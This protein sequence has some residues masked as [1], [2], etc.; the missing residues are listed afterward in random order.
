MAKRFARSSLKLKMRVRFL[1]CSQRTR[2]AS[3]LSPYIASFEL[4]SYRRKGARLGDEM[5]FQKHKLASR[6]KLWHAIRRVASGG[7]QGG[8]FSFLPPRFISCPPRYFLGWEKLL[9]CLN[10]WFRPGKAFEFRRRPFFYGDHLI[11]TET[12]PQS[13]SGTMKKLCPPNFDFP[14][15]D[16]A[17]LAKPLHVMEWAYCIGAA[18]ALPQLKC[19]Q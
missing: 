12:S 3:V 10:L 17:K 2:G 11:F 16:L 14:P 19:H 4:L 8:Q 9:V 15:P 1:A 7:G 13:N 5:I 6:F 18:K